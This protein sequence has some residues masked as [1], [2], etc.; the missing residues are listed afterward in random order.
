MSTP[1]LQQ[2]FVGLQGQINQKGQLYFVNACTAIGL[3]IT[4]SAYSNLVPDGQLIIQTVVL[5]MPD[6]NTVLVTG[7]TSSFDYID[8]PV[9]VKFYISDGVLNDELILSFGTQ[10]LSMPGVSWFYVGNPGYAIT[11]A[12]AQ[13]PVTGFVTGTIS[14][15]VVLDIEIGF[16]LTNNIWL[17][18]ATCE[19]PY[20]GISNFFQLVGGINLQAILPPPFNIFS[21]L[22]LQSINLAYNKSSLAIEYIVLAI[23]TDPNHQ[24]NILP[25]VIVTGLSFICTVNNPGDNKTRSAA[26]L[27]SG[28]FTIGPP[29]ANTMVVSANVPDFSASVSLEEGAIQLGDLITMFLPGVTLDLKSEISSFSLNIDPSAQSYMIDCGIQSDWKFFTLPNGTSFTMTAL[30]MTISSQ[31]GTSSGQIAGTFHIGD[32]NT[33]DGSGVDLTVFAGYAA[34]AW[35]FGARTGQDQVISLIAIAYT[36]LEPFGMAFLPEWVNN[37]VLDIKNVS[38]LATIPDA[39]EKLPDVYNFSG[40]VLWQ[41]DYNSF[42]LALDATVDITYSDGKSSGT[43]TGLTDLF[44]LKFTIGYQFGEADPTLVYLMWEG[45]K[46]TYLSD[47]TTKTDTITFAI[48]GM[49][50][51]EIITDFIASFSPGFTLPA[52]WNMLNSVNLDGLSFVYTRNE[53]DP[54]KNIIKGT[55]PLNIDLGFIKISSINLTKDV[56]GLFL[57]F[58]GAFLGIP[59]S[60]ANPDTKALS[61]KGSNAQN[62]PAVPGLGSQFFD[63]HFLG[64]GQHVGIQGASSYNSVIE[65]VDAMSKAFQPAEPGSL[66]VPTSSNPPLVYQQES[67][68]L[69]GADFTLAKFYRI[70]FVFNDPNLYGLAISITKDAKFLGNLNFEILYKKINDSIGMYQLDLQLP[71]EFRH[72]EFGEVSFTLPV[73]GIQIYTNGDFY[74]DFGFPASITDF[75]RSFTV[76]VFPFIGQGGFY[77]GLLSGATS[78]NIPS[79]TCGYFGTVVEFGLGLSLGVGKTVDE[80]ILK[81]GLSLTAV[82]IFQGTIALFT[83]TPGNGAQDD[84]YYCLQ[85][86]M[87]LTGRIYGSVDFAIISASLD[88]TAYIYVIFRIESYMAIPIEFT[89]GVSVSLRVKINLGLFSI[90]ISLSFSATI[91]AS[92]VIGQNHLQDAQW[93]KCT[94]SETY[95]SSAKRLLAGAPVNIVWQHVVPDNGNTYTL[96]LYLMPHLTVSGEGSKAGAQYVAM[97]YIDTAVPASAVNITGTTA[98]ATG[99]FYWTLGA[100]LGSSQNSLTTSWIDQ[101]DITADQLSQLLCYFNTRAN[102]EAPFN[103][104]NDSGNDIQ[105]FLKYFFTVS[106]VPVDDTD[107]ATM[108]AAVFPAIPELLLQAIYNGTA[109]TL[110]NFATESMTGN[111]GYI[112]DLS[113]LIA[114]MAVQYESAATASYYDN[115]ECSGF[116]DQYYQ[117]QPDL[118]IPTFIFTDFISS[119][120]KSLLQNALDAMSAAGKT[121]MPVSE[122]MS[123][124]LT[125]DNVKNAGSMI[126][127]FLLYGL[128]LPAPPDLKTGKVEPLYV[129]T[130][131][132]L[133][134]PSGI[135][136][137]K[138]SYVIQLS[139]PAADTWINFPGAGGDVLSLKISATELQRATDMSK[140]LITPSLQPGSPAPA[141]NYSDSPQLF[142]LGSPAIWNYPG[143]YYQG[144]KGTPSLW[145][146]PSNLSSL[147]AAQ[148]VTEPSFSLVTLTA[149]SGNPVKG[150]INTYTW[151]TAINLTLQKIKAPDVPETSMSPN[152]Y[153]LV[154]TDYTGIKYLQALI[155]YINSEKNGATDFISQI[156]LLWEPN[157]SQGS[158]G[159]YASDENGAYEMAF[160]KANLSTATNP[161]TGLMMA[162][163]AEET[164]TVY[165]TLN[166]PLD[167][168]SLLWECS[169]TLS[170]GYY[171]YYAKKGGAGL[172]AALFTDS[173]TAQLSLV[174][175]Y[176]NFIAEPFLN[177][178]VIGDQINSNDTVVYAEAPT[179][180]TRLATLQAGCL[181]F[182]VVRNNPGEYNAVNPLPTISEDTVY[183]ENQFNLIGSALEGISAYQNLLPS[184]PVD[185]LD[186]EQADQLSSGAYTTQ[187]ETLEWNYS[188]IIPYY[189]YVQAGGLLDTMNPYA[190]TGDLV[191]MLLNWQDMFGNF[192]T[193]GTAVLRVD[194]QMLYTDQIV[195]LSQWPASAPSYEFQLNDKLPAVKL[196]FCFDTSRYLAS[197]GAGIAQNDLQI[198]LLLYYQLSQGNDLLL[199]FTVSIDG[200]AQNPAGTVRSI[201]VNGFV[202][203]YILPIIN[204]L[205]AIVTTGTAPSPSGIP[206]PYVITSAIDPSLISAYTQLFPL[207]T[208]FNMRRVNHVDPNFL[209]TPGVARASTAIQPKSQAENFNSADSSLSLV[210]FA[211]NFEGVFANQPSAGI[212]LKIATSSEV[213]NAVSDA[214]S[215]PPVWVVRMDSTGKNGLKYSFKNDQVFFFAPIPLAVSLQSFSATINPYLSGQAYPAGKAVKKSFSSI[216]LDGWGMQFL[217]AVDKFLSPEYAVPAF[218]MDNGG[219]LQQVLDTKQAIAEAMEGTI[220]YIIEP[221][222]KSG[223]NI[224]NAQEIWKQQMLIQLSNAYTY[225][226][227]VQTPVTVNSCYTGSNNEPPAAPYVPAFYGNIQGYGPSIPGES[228]VIP[229]S[230]EYSLSTAKV[231]AAN[232][233]SWL[234]YMFQSKDTAR[235]RAFEFDHIQYNITHIENQIQSVPGMGD[236]LASSWLNFVIPVD[237]TWNT[238]GPITIP[239]PLRAYPTPPSVTG[240]SFS[241]PAAGLSDEVTVAEA[242]NW[243]YQ[244]DYKNSNAAQ[245]MMNLQ[246]QLN[247]PAGNGMMSASE[248]HITLDQ[249]LA[250]FMSVYPQISA[251]FDA[252]LLKMSST[253]TVDSNS[254]GYLAVQAFIEVIQSVATAW[255]A[256]NQVNPVKATLQSK[257]NSFKAMDL[258]QPVLLNYSVTETG[259]DETGYLII[260]VAG[261]A[262]NTLNVIPGINITGYTAE[263]SGVPNSWLYYVMVNGT[264][265]YLHKDDANDDHFRHVFLQDLDIINIQNAWSGVS[266]TRNNELIETEGGQWEVTNPYFIYQTPMVMF[267]TKLIP[268]L[269]GCQA[270]NIASIGG[271]GSPRPL[272]E[273]MEALFNALTEDGTMSFLTKL[274]C[275]YT[276]TIAGS[277]LEVTIPVLLALP[278]EL[279]AADHGKEFADTLSTELQAWL[280]AHIEDSNNGGFTFLIE[281]YSGFDQNLLLLQLNFYLNLF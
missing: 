185:A 247:I 149:A 99:V 96:D 43:I 148:L 106:V 17:L 263:S 125:P 68:W 208:T 78:T 159:G 160:V 252:Y 237:A 143:D 194:Q 242:K 110:I 233:N 196:N 76:Q 40:E 83:P 25:G 162:F 124:T 273:N 47:S 129:L 244:F 204:W 206:V 249:A 181:G 88:I 35:S 91:S 183:L 21:D 52:P 212:V 20:P 171:M 246:L 126:S 59:I 219:L 71:D 281:V 155:T 195:S 80:G 205:N 85:G 203:A 13:I 77:F 229:A 10:Q 274:S 116:T 218:L 104:L 231:P 207:N 6:E 165:N 186:Q 239:V 11:V 108:E 264:K 245:D 270:I 45:I 184:G 37:P 12:E 42:H 3:P 277:G 144:I 262:A 224:G 48:T 179:V 54:T 178:V 39:S 280:T 250:Q 201:E 253:T 268:L 62:M 141:A 215:L 227:A 69:I 217:V 94:H 267:Y 234:S 120:A 279:S 114:A 197:G 27:I 93:N 60:S 117:Q 151:S 105:H 214:S 236:Y 175:T 198:Y 24:W 112:A 232:G 255:A 89:A 50:L 272:Q 140:I 192:P 57:G 259:Q 230:T 56:T 64:L 103:Y 172:D 156:Q 153:S 275:N 157:P 154:G 113:K 130:G 213:N 278:F 167:F 1:N 122:L 187:E 28:T 254:P 109:G 95:L 90:H 102:N 261:D 18:N 34:K 139:K 92:F 58:E 81:A 269:S 136:P 55:L 135:D 73:I 101:Q 191:H 118:S 41:L 173:G 128:R 31:Q 222:D 256:W 51:G 220:D 63:L 257:P 210:P 182:S 22:G 168:I 87:G 5:T 146:F 142:T 176:N 82:G 251:D 169:I 161:Q 177:G 145:K 107:S 248:E 53:T 137:A 65:A 189:K 26:Y 209:T 188:G 202:Q 67:N 193:Q 123:I 134:V 72:L 131:Q 190:G 258:P 211:T 265:V 271:N 132:Q 75:S 240:Q 216:D 79:T 46:C 70:S 138:D 180:N 97:L 61:G 163:A 33:N 84:T 15:G 235:Y 66:P 19:A 16:P 174:I 44:G 29:E 152:M 260:A 221:A 238:V 223:A 226:A 150:V 166:T 49:S 133:P 30:Q 111:G 4:A 115:D 7:S 170:G 86:T 158:S 38:F 2:I 127:R 276:Y 200:T 36:F 98:L 100:L 266:I 121:S 225:T 119:V 9:S 199:D 8:S 32:T 243:I 241:Y 23:A 228:G 74:L 14:A 147:L 164:A